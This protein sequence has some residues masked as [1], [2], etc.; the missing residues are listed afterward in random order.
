MMLRA[1][2]SRRYTAVQYACLDPRTGVLRIA[3]A[4]MTGPVILSARGNLELKL[5]GIPP[6][7]FST[8]E[9][10]SETI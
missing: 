9:Y 3:S 5:R 6:G 1:V 4:G 2:S 10:E 7:M 8:T